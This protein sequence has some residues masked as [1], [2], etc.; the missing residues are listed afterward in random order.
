M[1]LSFILF[2]TNVNNVNMHRIILHLSVVHLRLLWVTIEMNI[3]ADPVLKLN[4][5]QV[6]LIDS[7][8][9]ILCQEQEGKPLHDLLN[10]Q[11]SM[12]F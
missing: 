3:D 1:I 7:G 12:I 10:I 4:I 6:G 8:L 5:T 2:Q 11:S 9:C